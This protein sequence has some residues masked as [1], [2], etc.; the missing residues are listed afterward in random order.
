V[1]R[2]DVAVGDDKW[3]TQGVASTAQL[4]QEILGIETTTE[5][6]V[7]LVREGLPV[8]SFAAV[9]AHTGLSRE[10]LGRIADIQVRTVQRRKGRLQRDESDRL[11]RVARIYAM[12]EAVL[13]S[14]DAAERWM[15]A[16]NWALDGAR[17]LEMLDTEVAARE[18]E[19]TLGRI[20]D[21]IFA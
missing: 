20:D 11:T 2:T 10:A 21:G 3:Y 13:G 9:A 15:K 14:R 7:D 1:G 12:A 16:P 5:G 6:L 18:I 19:D 17:P 8:R 4:T